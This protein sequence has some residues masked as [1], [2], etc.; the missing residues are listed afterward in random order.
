MINRAILSG[1]LL[2]VTGLCYAQE[3]APVH[4]EFVNGMQFSSKIADS[5]SD[6]FAF[7]YTMVPSIII[8]NKFIVSI[9]AKLNMY[10][11]SH[12]Q[13]QISQ[14]IMLGICAAYRHGSVDFEAS[15]LFGLWYSDFGQMET[16]ASLYLNRGK[17]DRSS[18][19]K[20]GV[21][22]LTPYQKG[23]QGGL[24]VSAGIGL[25]FTLK[26]SVQLDGK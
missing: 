11:I 21:S 20:I 18:F 6:I 1:I 19:Y 8:S 4:F 24:F 25:R 23:A 12:P 7:G 26:K 3:A 17:N 13:P 14:D 5:H 15:H 16:G 2:L 10:A 22:Y 9:P